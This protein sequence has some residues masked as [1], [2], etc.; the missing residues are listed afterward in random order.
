VNLLGL[1]ELVYRLLCSTPAELFAA[2]DPSS[3]D[4]AAALKPP[5]TTKKQVKVDDRL[6][7]YLRL[8]C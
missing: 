7:G 6:I 5:S 2:Y 3:Q 4:F 1:C 8:I